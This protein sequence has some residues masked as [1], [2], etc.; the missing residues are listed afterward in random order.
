MKLILEYLRSYFFEHFRWK[1]YLGV[2]LF[3][4]ALITFNY[5]LDFEH[6]VIGRQGFWGECRYSCCSM[7]WPITAFCYW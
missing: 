2:F 1:L 4:G 7:G 6:Q 3:I 5:V